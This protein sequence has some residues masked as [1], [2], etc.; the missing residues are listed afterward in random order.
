M[1]DKLR[2]EDYRAA[3]MSAVC[4]GALDLSGLPAS[5]A[6]IFASGDGSCAGGAADAH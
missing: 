4:Q 3:R 5:G 6:F 1:P 2:Q